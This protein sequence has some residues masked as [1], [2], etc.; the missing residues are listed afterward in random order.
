MT[1]N[2]RIVAAI[3]ELR[4]ERCL[5]LTLLPDS[6]EVFGDL[7]SVKCSADWT[8]YHSEHFSGVDL[9]TALQAAVAKKHYRARHPEAIPKGQKPEVER[10][11]PG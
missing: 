11:G 3:D 10:K 2:D 1:K 5:S 4:S 6:D 7:V 8:G 9:L